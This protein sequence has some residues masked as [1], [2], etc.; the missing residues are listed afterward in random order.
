[1]KKK[2]NYMK[3]NTYEVTE[4]LETLAPGKVLTPNLLILH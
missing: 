2:A 3:E 1:M 4:Y